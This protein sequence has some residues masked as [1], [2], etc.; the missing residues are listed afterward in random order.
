[1]EQDMHEYASGSWEVALEPWQGGSCIRALENCMGKKCMEQ[2]GMDGHPDYMNYMYRLPMNWAS[3]PWD[4]SM[5]VFSGPFPTHQLH[6]LCAESIP[7]KSKCASSLVQQK[8]HDKRKLP[9]AHVSSSLCSSAKPALAKS[10]AAYLP[11]Q[12]E[13]KPA[14]LTFQIKQS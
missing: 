2:E 12:P 10:R 8:T 4:T 5:K 1:M 14:L 3:H 6:L 9:V 13:Q 7:Q 11:S